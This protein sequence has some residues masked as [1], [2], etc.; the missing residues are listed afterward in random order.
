MLTPLSFAQPY[1]VI[2]NA[3][4][5]SRDEWHPGT[6]P[7]PHPN[8]IV[9]GMAFSFFRMEYTP[10]GLYWAASLSYGNGKL[11]AQQKP[12]GVYPVLVQLNPTPYNI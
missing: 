6:L 5:Y 7:R 12:P 10:G 1:H 9:L 4:E 11:V 2:G 3:S 8:R